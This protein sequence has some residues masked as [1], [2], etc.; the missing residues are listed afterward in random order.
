MA[1]RMQYHFEPKQGWMNDP[2]GLI[3]FKGQYHIFFQHNPHATHWDTMHWGHAVSKDLLHFEECEIALYPD[4]PYE[5]EGGCFSGS[6]IEKDGRLYLFYTSVSK[7]LGQTQSVAYSDDGVHFTKYEKNPVIASFPA[8]GSKDFRDP[9]V[10][11]YQNTYYMVVGSAYNR[12]GRVLFYRSEDLLTWEYQGVLYESK[13][14]CNAIE[15]PD[16]FPLGDKYVLMFSKME[17]RLHTTQFVIGTFDGTTFLP[18]SYQCPEVGPQFYAPQSFL[19]PDGRRLM[20]G[21]FYDWKLT[22][23]ADAV[24]AGALS[25]PRELSLQDGILY[26]RPCTESRE[27]LLFSHPSILQEKESVTVHTKTDGDLTYYGRTT[28]VSVFEDTSHIEV[29]IND[30]ACNISALIE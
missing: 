17:C 15:C 23:E 26:A 22:P 9:K 8:D 2:N 4:Q 12:R 25:L 1:E 18:E 6:A 14:Y 11:A 10:F 30:G 16:F 19:A 27:M 20:I 3:Y 28:Q 13:E 7:A 5:D 24:S 21:W 29:F